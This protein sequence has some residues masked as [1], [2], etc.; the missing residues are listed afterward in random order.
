MK[1]IIT[2]QELAEILLVD[3]QNLQSVEHARDEF[4]AYYEK[5]ISKMMNKPDSFFIRSMRNRDYNISLLIS[6][7]NSKFLVA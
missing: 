7:E 5:V 3:A 6:C 2:K 1:A 4:G